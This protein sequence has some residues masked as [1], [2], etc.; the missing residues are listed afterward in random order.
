MCIYIYI[1]I[2]I[3][4]HSSIQF[5]FETGV[6]SPSR[7]ASEPACRRTDAGAG[8]PRTRELIIMMMIKYIMT[9]YINTLTHIY[10]Q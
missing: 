6:L 8:I 3:Y 4:V 7:G 1:Y 9:C 10:Y 2:Y 5:F